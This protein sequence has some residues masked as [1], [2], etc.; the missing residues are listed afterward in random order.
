MEVQFLPLVPNAVMPIAS[1]ATTRSPVPHGYGV[2]E[3]CLPFTAATALGLLVR[4]PITFGLCRAHEVPEGG[5]PFRSPLDSVSTE[6]SDPRVFYVRD[7]T[8]CRFSGNAFTFESSGGGVVPGL[9]FFDREDQQHLFKVHLPF[10]CR[11]T[12]GIDT[13]FLSPINR[14][15]PF[16]VLSGLVETDWYSSP[17]NLI[18]RKPPGARPVHVMKG[19]ALAQ[20]VFL[21]RA[22]RRANVR[23][24]PEHAKLSRD[25]KA[26]MQAWDRQHHQ[27]RSAYK[28]LVR[29]QHGRLDSD[30]S[31]TKK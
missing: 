7:D 11:T 30:T 19:T 23:I 25:L 31:Q 20:L 27:D 21:D 10:L 1:P 3:Q 17:V 8:Q 16:D 13:L 22:L 15:A 28:K 29:T 5:H 12:A 2:Q 14:A 9:S 6:P 26:A 4:S 24:L 18:L